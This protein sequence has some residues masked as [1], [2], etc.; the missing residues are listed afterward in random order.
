[1]S[2]NTAKFGTL[3][4]AVLK[5]VWVL[6]WPADSQSSYDVGHSRSHRHSKV[7]QIRQTPEQT[8]ELG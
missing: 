2:S 4:N 1:M 7:S 5:E 8:F 6:A 3:V